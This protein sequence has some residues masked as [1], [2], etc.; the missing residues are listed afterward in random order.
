MAGLVA[1]TLDGVLRSHVGERVIPEGFNLYQSLASV[2]RIAIVLD[3]A[4]QA[5]DT[6]WLRK[7]GFRDYVLLVTQRQLGDRIDQY[8]GLMASGPLELVVDADP[9]AVAGAM[10]LGVPALLFA[11]PRT[12][13]PEWRPDFDRTPRPWSQVAHRVREARLLEQAPVD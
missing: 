10:D 1:V 5:L 13:R 7:E 4:D 8:R 11:H 3:G 12:S 9:D 2:H 6:L